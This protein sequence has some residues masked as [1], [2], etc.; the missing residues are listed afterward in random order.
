MSEK[1]T[2]QQW[3]EDFKKDIG[4]GYEET[5]MVTA[6]CEHIHKDCKEAPTTLLK[7]EREYKNH[8]IVLVKGTL[9]NVKP[10]D[11]GFVQS[12]GD[13]H[14][15]PE[16]WG[17]DM[18]MHELGRDVAE[19]EYAIII[20]GM[21]SCAETTVNV[22]QK[23]QLSVDDIREAQNRAKEYADSVIMNLQQM[24]AFLIKEQ[25]STLSFLPEEKRGY[26]YSGTI[27]G[28]NV[29]WTN[30]VKDFALVFSRKEMNFASTPLEITFDDMNSPKQLILRKM[31]V[32]APMFDQT[33]VRIELV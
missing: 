19:N 31:C 20:K 13:W 2:F 25:I 21:E 10:L 5:T 14:R 29:F 12:L 23:G 28:L 7:V 22:K 1:K 16:G 18:F 11:A 26:H 30:S 27:G 6:L 17:M 8:Q 24:T 3:L 9:R 32:A 4:K 15:N 33:V